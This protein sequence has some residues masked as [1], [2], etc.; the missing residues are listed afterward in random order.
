MKNR[1][2]IIKTSSLGDL[3]LALPHIDVILAHHRED[4]V[5][6][7][8]SAPYAEL[9][10]HHP[11]MNVRLLDR[12]RWFSK[13][14]TIGTML[15]VRRQRFSVIYD[16]QGNRTS[17]LIVRFSNAPVRVG[18]QPKT[19]Y[20]F[21]PDSTYAPHTQQN[22]FDRLNQTLAAAG[23]AQ[24]D[25][26]CTLYPP[27]TDFSFVTQWMES[28]ELRIRRFALIHAGSSA[29]WPSKRWPVEH[30]LKLAGMIEKT[31]IR[32][33]WVGDKADREINNYLVRYAGIDA[34][35]QF[36]L[37]QLYLMGKEALF[38]VTNDSG[39]MHIFAASGTPV[40]SF[41]GPTSWIRSHAAG[42]KERVITN[43]VECSPCFLGICPQERRHVCLDTMKPEAVFARIKAEI[44]FS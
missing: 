1:I 41:F 44:G 19:I 42:Q 37:L 25:S 10:L 20:H 28:H 17:R 14:S 5:W 24:A 21:H 26:D 15:W 23:L 27:P 36:S 43:N 9:F 32:C 11:H 3:F 22:V 31:G 13:D 30:Y 2:L 6:L 35:E 18:T 38:A 12:S 39:P 8:T 4:R 16:L 40:F 7:L 29:K 33:V 34:T